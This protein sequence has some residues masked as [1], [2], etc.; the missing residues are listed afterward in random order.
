MLDGFRLGLARGFQ[1]QV[2]LGFATG[3]QKQ[4]ISMVVGSYMD[5]VLAQGLVSRTRSFLVLLSNVFSR[6]VVHGCLG[7]IQRLKRLT[8]SHSVSIIF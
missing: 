1:K 2:F 4:V 7:F 3:F 5:G 6:R 8:P